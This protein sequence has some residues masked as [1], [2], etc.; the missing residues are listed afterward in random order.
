MKKIEQIERTHGHAAAVGRR[1]YLTQGLLNV[2]SDYTNET[3]LK[4]PND[5]ATPRR[6]CE[7]TGD[8]DP[9][10]ICAGKKFLFK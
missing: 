1:A 3:C 8:E 7:N 5:D 9:C 2:I 6:N 10:E 4:H